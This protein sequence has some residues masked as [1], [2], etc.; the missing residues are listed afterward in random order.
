ILGHIGESE[1]EVYLFLEIRENALCGD[2]RVVDM[3]AGNVILL[4]GRGYWLA[5]RETDDS[6]LV[7]LP[8]GSPLEASLDDHV[9]RRRLET[10]IDRLDVGRDQLLYEWELSHSFIIAVLLEKCGHVGEVEIAKVSG[11]VIEVAVTLEDP[12]VLYDDLGRQLTGAEAIVREQ[13][14]GVHEESGRLVV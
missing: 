14:S 6:D 7:F 3:K 2:E 12:P 1:N 9:R 8:W 11:V 13:V 4:G 10:R 5:E